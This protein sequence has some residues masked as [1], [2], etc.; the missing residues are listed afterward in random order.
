MDVAAFHP[1]R[2]LCRL[3][4]EVREG[5]VGPPRPIRG[6][7]TATGTTMTPTTELQSAAVDSHRGVAGG[8]VKHLVPLGAGVAQEQLRRLVRVVAVEVE[9]GGV[10]ASQLDAERVR[11][12][13]AAA[14]PGAATPRPT[15]C[16][17]A[18]P[19]EQK[20]RGN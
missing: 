17:A 16:R 3:R 1:H 19:R 4:Q 20:Q 18:A 6:G 15:G 13:D 10:E 9:A 14:A 11:D 7:C 2:V 5:Q 12:A 8:D